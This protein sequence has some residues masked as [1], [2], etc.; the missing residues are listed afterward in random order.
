MRILG[1]SA[2]ITTARGAV[3]DGRTCGRG[4][5][6]RFTRRKHDSRFPAHASVR[7]KQA[8]VGLD[9]V[10]NVAFYDSRSWPSACSRPISRSRRGPQSFSM[11]IPVWLREKLFQSRPEARAEAPRADYD[12]S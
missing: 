2:S 3:E 11:A 10:D 12:W 8:G 5:E 4:S 7:L 6:E 9:A 1:I